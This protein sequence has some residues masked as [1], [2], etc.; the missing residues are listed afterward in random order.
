MWASS[1][2]LPGLVSLLS[3]YSINPEPLISTYGKRIH[4]I[5]TRQGILQTEYR[6]LIPAMGDSLRRFLGDS[7]AQPGRRI[8][9]LPPRPHNQMF[10]LNLLIPYG[11]IGQQKARGKA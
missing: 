11:R 10:P 6:V 1:E 2:D 4:Q 7:E 9:S 3:N 5:K 8:P